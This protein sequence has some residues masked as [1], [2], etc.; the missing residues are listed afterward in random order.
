[1]RRKGI[2]TRPDGRFRFYLGIALDQ[3]GR[4]EEAGKLLASLAEQV[5]GKYAAEARR[6][7]QHRRP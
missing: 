2:L 5:F 7:L 3:A 1:M 6:Y 4:K